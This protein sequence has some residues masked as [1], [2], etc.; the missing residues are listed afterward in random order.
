MKIFDR[1]SFKNLSVRIKI[2]GGF[3]IVL[4]LLIVVGSIAIL[5]T[6]EINQT[7]D[8][9]VGNLA[10]DQV[11]ASDIAAQ[12]I[13]VRLRA[14]KYIEDQDQAQLDKYEEHLSNLTIILETADVEIQNPERRQMLDSIETKSEE[15]IATFEEIKKEISERETIL[16]EILEIKGAQAENV[17][18]DLRQNAFEAGDAVAANYAGDAQAAILFMRFDAYKYLVSGDA[19]FISTSSPQ[20]M[21]K[22]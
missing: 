7:V 13:R 15:Y 18:R 5:R 8:N 20:D 3:A 4:A 2:L 6:N 22:V 16:T 1:I 19:D 14:N 11:V 21:K 10:T 9:L 12:I 17:L